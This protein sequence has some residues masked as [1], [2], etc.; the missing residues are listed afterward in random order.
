MSRQKLA[1]LL[2]LCIV[3]PGTRPEASACT[4]V[5]A[6]RKAT[7]DG[8]VLMSSSCDG[9]RMGQIFLVPAKEY[10]PGER[11]PM[12]LN[13]KD[14][15]GHLPPIQRTHRCLI[16]GH[17]ALGGMNE[18]GVSIGIEF[19]PMRAGLDS[20]NGLVGPYSN[21]WTTSLIANGLMRIR[22][23][24]E[25][26][27]L[28]GAMVEQHGFLYTW[29]PHAGVALPIADKTEIWLLEIFGPEENWTAASGTPGGVWCA[30][31]IPDDAV[32][33][34]R[35]PQPDRPSGPGGCGP[36]HGFAQRFLAGQTVGILGR[37]RTVRLERSVRGA[38]ESEATC[39]ASGG[40]F[41]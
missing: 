33:V 17:G 6:G 7:A 26:V 29:A 11:V 5:M 4:T 24:R 21:H 31:R 10:A 18:F 22:T 32:G 38:P 15:V 2:I 27:R 30:Q 8:S 12:S 23:A 39:C 13:G 20:T 37:V 36:L 16:L 25:A 28:I 9:D 19:I 3:P 14:V 34:K 35:E 40:R 41:R 1:L